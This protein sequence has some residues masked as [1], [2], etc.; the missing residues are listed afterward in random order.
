MKI[1][2][3]DTISVVHSEIC[4]QRKVLKDLFHLFLK[5]KRKGKYIHKAETNKVG[6]KKFIQNLVNVIFLKR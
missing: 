1:V 4:T 2:I 3:Y 6:N 5:K